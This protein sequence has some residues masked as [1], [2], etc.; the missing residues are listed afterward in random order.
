[1][2][3]KIV[4][5][6]TVVVAAIIGA[7]WNLSPQGEPVATSDIQLVGEVKRFQLATSANKTSDV[8]WY[9]MSGKKISFADF[10]GKVVLLNYWATWC[11]P[12]IK[13]LPSVNRL[14]S[15]LA[16]DDFTVVAINVDRNGSNTAPAMVKKLALGS[17]D[18]YIDTRSVSAR[19]L[20]VRGMPTTFLFDR[21]GRK[22]GHLEGGAEWDMPES[23]ALVQYFIDHPT[24][25]SDLPKLADAR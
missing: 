15:T 22:I 5:I 9:D 23:M 10:K 11:L 14:Q 6:A 24:Y 3:K 20:G 7:G 18:L 25:V 13:E 17:L 1:M 8:S 4:T 21:Q 16:N 19:E 2:N 12:C